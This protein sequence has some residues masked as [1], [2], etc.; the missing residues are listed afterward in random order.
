MDFESR[1]FFKNFFHESLEIL[2]EQQRKAYF[3]PPTAWFPLEQCVSSFNGHTSHLEILL[4]CRFWLSGSGVGLPGDPQ[5][6]RPHTEK[7]ILI[8][9]KLLPASSEVPGLSLWTPGRGRTPWQPCASLARQLS[10]SLFIPSHYHQRKRVC[11]HA[12]SCLQ[13]ASEKLKV[14]VKKKKLPQQ[15]LRITRIREKMG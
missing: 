2:R 15:P 11:R 3:F 7:Q 10:A 4:R 5:T 8:P 14:Q 1:A 13:R 9:S 6:V 12:T